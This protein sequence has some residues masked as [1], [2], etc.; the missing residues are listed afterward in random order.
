M[1]EELFSYLKYSIIINGI[2][3]WKQRKANCEYLYKRFEALNN[4]DAIQYMIDNG[5]YSPIKSTLHKYTNNI[6]MKYI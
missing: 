5:L 6:Y 2:E 3:S 1:S 4:N